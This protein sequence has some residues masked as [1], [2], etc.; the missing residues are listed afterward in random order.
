MRKIIS[1][2][3]VLFANNQEFIKELRKQ[4]VKIGEGCVID[5]SAIFGSEPYLISIGNKV[6][7]T[8]GVK[9][10]THDGGLWVLRNLGLLPESADRFGRIEV[11]NNCNIGWNAIIMPGVIIGDNCVIGCGAIVTKSIPDNSIVAGVPARVIESIEEYCNKNK[12]RYVPTKH[13]SDEEKKL[14]LSEVL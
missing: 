11:G 6:R 4:G 8:H 5:K 9:F 14:Y 3:R 12:T 1:K 10:I 7:I 2:I 13:L